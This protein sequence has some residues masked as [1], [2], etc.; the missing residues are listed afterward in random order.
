MQITQGYSRDHR[1]ELNQV[2]LQLLVERQA[3][4]PLLMEPLSGNSS[5]QASFRQTIRA[6]I[7]QLQQ[8]VGIEYLGADSALYTAE[9][10][11]Q[12]QPFFWFSRIPETLTLAR[13]L[14]QVVAP[15]WMCTPDKMNWCS[16]CVRYAEVQQRCLVVWSPAAYRRALSTVNKQC[17]KGSSTELKAFEQ[18]CRQDFAC[19]ADAQQALARFEK[20]LSFTVVGASRIVAV[21]HYATSG[22]PP[23][24]R[25]PDS[26]TYRLDGALASLPAERTRRLQQQSCFIIATNQVDSEALSD[27]ELLHAYKDQQKVERGFRFLKDP[28]FMASTLYLKSPKRIMALMMVMALCLLVYAAL[29]YRIRQALTAHDQTFPNQKGEPVRNASARWVFQFFAGIHV[30][31][32]AQLQVLVLNLNEHHRRLLALL[33]ERYEM[34]YSD[35]G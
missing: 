28:L 13:D 22:R 14:L 18:L 27:E 34:L 20:R 16:L 11:P 33:G 26:F 12:L 25:P 15:D 8:A 6:H 31:V 23:K 21:P 1:P 35:S 17:L 3:G 2:V 32:I 5:D 29:E 19:E 7:N 4:I 10:L 9:T 30:L 24:G